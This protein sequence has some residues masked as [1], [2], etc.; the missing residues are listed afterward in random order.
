MSDVWE[1]TP[2][3][4]FCHLQAC[5]YKCALAVRIDGTDMMACAFA[6]SAAIGSDHSVNAIKAPKEESR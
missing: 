4:P 2:F 1:F 5:N 3:C 6:V